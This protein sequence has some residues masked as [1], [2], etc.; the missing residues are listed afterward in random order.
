MATMH[1]AMPKLV[2]VQKA[3]VSVIGCT[4]VAA[5]LKSSTFKILAEANVEGHVAVIGMHVQAQIFAD[6]VP[7]DKGVVPVKVRPNARKKV[8]RNQLQEA[9][10]EPA[11][12]PCCCGS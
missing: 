10:D 7:H 8:M 2:L 4:L 9:V 11:G 6:L 3:C 1:N 12:V 5:K